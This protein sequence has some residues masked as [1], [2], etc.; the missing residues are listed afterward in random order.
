M[1]WFHKIR[2]WIRAIGLRLRFLFNKSVTEGELDE[3]LRFHLEMEIQQNLRAGHSPNE[4]R[5]QAF[6]S[7]PKPKRIMEGHLTTIVLVG[8]WIVLLGCLGLELAFHPRF[9]HSFGGYYS[10]LMLGYAALALAAVLHTLIK[11]RGSDLRGSGMGIIL[12]GCCRSGASRVTSATGPGARRGSGR[13]LSSDDP[14]IQL[15]PR[16][17]CGHPFEHGSWSTAGG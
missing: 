13:L 17:N 9:Y 4:A 12:E 11:N 2:Y 3:E 14:R 10:L 7:F 15:A 16:S 5:R 6:L 1:I 8:P